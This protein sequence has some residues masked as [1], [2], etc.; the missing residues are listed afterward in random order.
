MHKCSYAFMLQWRLSKLCKTVLFDNQG[1]LKQNIH[2]HFKF[3]IKKLPKLKSA[4]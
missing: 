2:F 3:D 4:E 1:N